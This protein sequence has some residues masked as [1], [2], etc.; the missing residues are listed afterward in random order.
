MAAPVARQEVRVP[1]NKQFIVDQ[2][3]FGDP[4]MYW[5]M[6]DQYRAILL[7]RL[8]QSFPDTYFD[9]QDNAFH[10]RDANNEMLGEVTL[11]YTHP[12]RGGGVEEYAA[13][14]LY[15]FGNVNVQ[16]TA[17]QIIETFLQQ[18]QEQAGG[19]R[20]RGGKGKKSRKGR[21]GRKGRK[22]AKGRK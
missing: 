15:P 22:T 10:I 11:L 6:K 19:R 17:R 3:P 9:D 2:A 18:V 12:V 7:N 5:Q 8:R 20:G 1:D 13:F 14:N 21:K 16:N 4:A